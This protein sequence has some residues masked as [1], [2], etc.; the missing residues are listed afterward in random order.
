MHTTYALKVQGDI[1]HVP[2]AGVRFH[3]HLTATIR[4]QRLLTFGDNFRFCTTL[5]ACTTSHKF[6]HLCHPYV[7]WM[8]RHLHQGRRLCVKP[9]PQLLPR[10]ITI[11]A[12]PTQ[13]RW[14]QAAE[15]NRCL[16]GTIRMWTSASWF[17]MDHWTDNVP[18]CTCSG[19][20]LFIPMVL[21]YHTTS[22]Q[23][24]RSSAASAKRWVLSFSPAVFTCIS[25]ECSEVG[26]IA[27]TKPDR[28]ARWNSKV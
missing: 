27:S 20:A 16:G 13:Q 9:A 15:E 4:R 5:C 10:C 2:G 23:F 26:Q 17:W 7:A 6:D 14:Q 24:W 1:G 8:V 3:H 22:G 25:S 28:T 18:G 12:R 19:A 21:L 11:P